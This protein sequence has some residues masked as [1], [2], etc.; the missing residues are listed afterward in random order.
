MEDVDHDALWRAL[1]TEVWQRGAHA[2]NCSV[3]ERVGT[4]RG[5]FRQRTQHISVREDSA[6][7]FYRDVVDGS[8]HRGVGFCSG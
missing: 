2:L 5:G 4:V 8:Y 3:T 1:L 6:R 7:L